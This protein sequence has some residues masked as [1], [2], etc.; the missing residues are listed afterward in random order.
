MINPY[1]EILR[2]LRG[3]PAML[4]VG[5]RSRQAVE[6]VT[7]FVWDL[8]FA[9]EVLLMITFRDSNE[10]KKAPPP[11]APAPGQPVPPVAPPE[12]EPVREFYFKWIRTANIIALE[13]D[14]NVKINM[15]LREFKK[16]ETEPLY[17]D[18][19]ASWNVLNNALSRHILN[20]LRELGIDGEFT[21]VFRS[22]AG[23]TLTP[24]E[25]FP[26]AAPASE[27]V[28]VGA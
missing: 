26:V 12:I 5:D 9:D 28:P 27:P 16:L 4:E 19:L 22:S 8:F 7:G 2:T 24:E 21:G 11:Q 6:V 13:T 10:V 18:G 23:Q 17:T 14:A 3:R 1:V 25:A 15:K 20:K